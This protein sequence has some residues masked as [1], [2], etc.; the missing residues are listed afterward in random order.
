MLQ[1]RLDGLPAHERRALQEASVIGPV[2]WDQALA[3]LDAQAALR[4]P[5]WC[6]ASSRCRGPRPTLDGMREYAFSH[7]SCTR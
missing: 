6:G 5:R 7:Q 2:F 4:C 3:A 1:A